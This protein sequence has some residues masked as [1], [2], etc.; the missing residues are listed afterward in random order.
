MLKVVLGFCHDKVL[1]LAQIRCFFF[2]RRP[3]TVPLGKDLWGVNVDT[4]KVLIFLPRAG[5]IFTGGGR[6][7]LASG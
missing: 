2:N 5:I 3:S 6:G 7:M 1:R 4:K